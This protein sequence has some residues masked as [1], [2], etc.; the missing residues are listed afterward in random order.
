M[1]GE[2]LAHY[3]ILRKLGGGGMGIVYEAEDLKLGRR[4]ALKF[5]PE[6]LAGDPKALQRF[7][8]EA[9]AASALNHPNIC[10]IHEVEEHDSRPFIVMEMLEGES[11]K[12]RLHGQPLPLEEVLEIGIQVADALDAAHNKGIVHRDIKPANIYVSP[13][14]QAKILDFGLAK[15]SPEQQMFSPDGSGTSLEDSLTA[16]GVVPGTAVYMSPE[17]VRSEEVDARSDLF[18]FGVVLYELAT[19]HKPFVGK[20]VVLTLEAILHQKPVSPLSRNAD[21]PAAFER[22]VG[23]ALEKKRDDRYGSAAQLRTDLEQLKKETESGLEPA[24]LRKSALLPR[25]PSKTFQGPSWYHRYLLLVMAGLLVAVL[26]AVGAWWFKHAR[27]ASGAP[28]TIAVVP[29]RNMTGDKNMDFLS[30]A[31]ADEIA[32]QLTYVPTLE[33]RPLEDSRKLTDTDPQQVGRTLHV[34]VVVSGHYL[35]QGSALRVTL[36]AVEVRNDRVF[37][38]GTV[39]AT[40]GDLTAMQK[41]IARQ[42]QQGFIPRL[43]LVNAP[44]RAGSQPKNP[45]AY[46]LYLRSSAVPHDPAPNKEAITLLEKVVK[47]DPKYAPAWQALG[48]RYYYD[49]AYS[50]G[51]DEAFQRS[52]AALER[53]LQLDPNLI[54]AAADLTQNRIEWGELDKAGE[55]EALVKRR[56]D[57]AEAHFTVAYVYRY[58]GLLEAAAQ[59]CD[60]ALN[61]DPGDFN[62]RSCAF[63]F[64][65]LGRAPKAM[66]YV[67]LDAHSQWA[68]NVTPAILLR[69]GQTMEARQAAERMTNDAP[70]YGALLQT[71]LQHPA[72]MAQATKATEPALM[73]LRDPEMKYL[74]ASL[75]SYCGQDQAAFDL[76]RGA[77]EQNYCAASALQV[78]P[79]W[80]RLREKPEFSELQGLAS[81]CQGR[82]LTALTQPG[83]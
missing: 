13:R 66:E 2:V 40:G 76:L 1:I 27:N 20:N 67:R 58:A 77:I 51:G 80:A 19:G 53:A 22:I 33:V 14:G 32:T 28:N 49:A 8:R 41:A 10:T 17:Q 82:F 12:Q 18:S 25:L 38:Q 11:L 42:V 34:A 29:F 59:E 36:E 75:L 83:R 23:K 54:S 6:N 21:L 68:R 31:L 52:T 43:G 37:W 79:L 69:A 45:Q 64:L 44:L 56:P 30:F 74:H 48:K 47:L 50:D 15:L 73:L 46:D 81:Q 39:A 4:V 60:A 26:T 5:I 71:C 16:E 24:A 9:R 62:L 55:A 78:D 72:E 70:W 3:R 35:K 7:L 63:V 65:E 61:L 57:N